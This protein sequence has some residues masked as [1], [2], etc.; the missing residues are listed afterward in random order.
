MIWAL[1]TNFEEFDIAIWVVITCPSTFIV[2]MFLFDVDTKCSR[3][4]FFNIFSKD[5]ISEGSDGGKILLPS[6]NC[7]WSSKWRKTIGLKSKNIFPSLSM[8]NLC[9][10]R[11]LNK[12]ENKLFVSKFKVCRVVARISP[13]IFKWITSVSSTFR[14]ISFSSS[15]D[16]F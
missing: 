8:C 10:H 15:K 11:P 13:P 16:F 14:V 6:E 1:F 2:K 12:T 7:N 9:S 4:S 3:R 5:R